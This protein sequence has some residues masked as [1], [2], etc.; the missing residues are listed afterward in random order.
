MRNI[1]FD[2]DGT[3]I[4]PIDGF[5]VSIN[6]TL[7]EFGRT[8]MSLDK[9]RRFIG[10]PIQETLIEMLGT[11]DP[12]EIK[13]AV[14]L[15]REHYTAVG[16]H[17]H[18]IYPDVREMLADL[19]QLGYPLFVATSKIARIARPIVEAL[20]LDLYFVEIYGSDPT[21]T[22]DDKSYLLET[23]IA[24]RRLLPETCWMVGDRKFDMVAARDNQMRPLGVSY[25]YGSIDEL[26]ASGA[27]LICATPHDVVRGIT[28]ESDDS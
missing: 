21:A 14:T 6:H 9:L 2:L 17:R 20:G 11:D 10:P 5:S 13:R 23:I 12:E 24:E 19:Y 28:A 15:Y 25:G 7:G 8:A 22:R 3:L 18:T 4:D 16:M 27:E 26:Q 1:F